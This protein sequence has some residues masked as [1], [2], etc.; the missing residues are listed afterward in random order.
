M[1]STPAIDVYDFVNLMCS[2][3]INAQHRDDLIRFYFNEFTTTLR[4][5]GYRGRVP[6]LLD[7]HVELLRCSVIELLHSLAFITIQFVDIKEI[8]FSA[9]DISS[10]MEDLVKK[11]CQSK[12]YQQH[13]KATLK[14]MLVQGTLA[15]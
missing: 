6:S 10:I 8:D 15:L 11:G 1:W 4:H 9:D 3:E 14:R 5:G 2:H 12:E 13:V 7:L